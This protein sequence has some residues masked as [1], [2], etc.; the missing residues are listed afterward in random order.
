[1]K[2]ARHVATS[3]PG[4][5]Q[6][7]GTMPH[8]PRPCH[9]HAET[10]GER[11]CPRPR[12]GPHRRRGRPMGCKARTGEGTGEATVEG[13]GVSEGTAGTAVGTAGATAEG[14]AG[15]AEAT[16]WTTRTSRRITSR[17]CECAPS[18]HAPPCCTTVSIQL[19]ICMAASRMPGCGMTGTIRWH[20][21]LIA[22]WRCGC[23][24]CVSMWH[25]SMGSHGLLPTSAHAYP[26]MSVHH[27]AYPCG[28]S[29]SG[30]VIN[31]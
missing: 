18:S 31:S 27:H 5:C 14:T 15:T 21:R 17:S 28:M 1:M 2:P 19:L 26:C 11:C 24:A 3:M 6:A 13:T 22:F 29:V 30:S 12:P 9:T 16:K 20:M 23:H 25:A 7:T 4:P 8:M 10:V